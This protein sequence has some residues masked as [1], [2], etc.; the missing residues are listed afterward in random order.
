MYLLVT[1]AVKTNEN[2]FHDKK[3]TVV[4]QQKS[5]YF[6]ISSLYAL[7]FYLLQFE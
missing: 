3:Q 2:S 4:K 1:I 7:T 5:V 6:V